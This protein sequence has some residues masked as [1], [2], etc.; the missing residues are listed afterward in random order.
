GA[1]LRRHRARPGEWRLRRPRR[2]DR[3]ERGAGAA[4]ARAVND[5]GAEF[6]AHGLASRRRDARPAADLERSIRDFLSSPVEAVSLSMNP[7]LPRISRG[8][9]PIH[10]P[11]ARIAAIIVVIVLGLSCRPAAVATTGAPTY[12]V[13][14]RH[15]TLY[16]G[17][18]RPGVTGDL[19]I[20][21][22]SLAALGDLSAARGKT[23]IDARGLA[24]AP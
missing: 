6:G 24:V 2:A 15:G 17:S 7:N 14:I 10:I 5:G 21:S 18:G 19:A 20:L 13:V 8:S 16:D 11:C 12:D 4:G 3:A 23:E 22:H 1:V 9:M